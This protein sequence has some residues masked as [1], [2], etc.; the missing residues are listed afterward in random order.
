MRFERSSARAWDAWRRWRVNRGASCS[1]GAFSSL[2]FDTGMFG[3]SLVAASSKW[4]LSFGLDVKRRPERTCPISRFSGPRLRTSTKAGRILSTSVSF[5]VC[6]P[7]TLR[8]GLNPCQ[9]SSSALSGFHLAPA[10]DP[11]R[12]SRLRGLFYTRHVSLTQRIRINGAPP[13]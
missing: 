1:T 13:T 7:R 5:A 9:S 6:T 3:F 11:A 4:A 2:F 12:R 10:G 8:R